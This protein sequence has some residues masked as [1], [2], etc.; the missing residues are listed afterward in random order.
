MPSRR[1]RT[2]PNKTLGIRYTELIPIIINAIQE[3]AGKVAMLAEGVFEND[4]R[5]GR[6]IEAA[7]D[8]RSDGRLCLG[9]TCV[10][11]AELKALL[12]N[13]AGQGSTPASTP[14]PTPEEDTTA[15]DEDATE[16]DD[17]SSATDEA[18]LELEDES[19]EEPPSAAEP[20][21]EGP[22]SNSETE[23]TDA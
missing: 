20:A 16:P 21:E 22:T 5:A 18:E 1:A 7:G 11:E 2:D 23:P 15:P 17:T 8:V 19:A 4:I 12:Q 10:T 3:L 14:E 6:N 13:Q 9:N